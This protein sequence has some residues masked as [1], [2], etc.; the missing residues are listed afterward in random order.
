MRRVSRCR[1]DVERARE[2]LR[3]CLVPGL[4][5]LDHELQVTL[6][7]DHAERVEVLTLVL[8]EPGVE[9]VDIVDV[10]TNH[11]LDRCHESQL[12]LLLLVSLA[13]SLPDQLDGDLQRLAGVGLAVLPQ[14]VDVARARL[15]Q[16]R[17][18]KL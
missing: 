16:R 15:A 13:D 8:V 12:L 17:G 14:Q 3:L 9:L 4:H 18:V 7:F 10:A 11:R 2:R 1:H 5:L 6:T